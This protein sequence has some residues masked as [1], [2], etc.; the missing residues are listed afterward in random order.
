MI[1]FSA[2]I[3]GQDTQISLTIHPRYHEYE[4]KELNFTVINSQNII[5]DINGDLI[6]NIYDILII[7]DMILDLETNQSTADLNLDGGINILDLSI[8]VNIVLNQ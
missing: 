6:V 8:L 3:S 1:Y 4:Q 5:G 2:N 7:V